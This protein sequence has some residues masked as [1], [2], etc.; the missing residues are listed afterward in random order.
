MLRSQS[1]AV[2]QQREEIKRLRDSYDALNDRFTERHDRVVQLERQLSAY[3]DAN[4]DLT[5]INMN[6]RE[7]LA[8]YGA[9]E[10]GCEWPL[11]FTDDCTCGWKMTIEEL[12]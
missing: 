1:F 6:L 8:K 3:K 10:G 7:A 5:H 4:D 2:A 9:H 12:Q 11:D